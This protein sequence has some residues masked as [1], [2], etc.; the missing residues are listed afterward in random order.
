MESVD[1]NSCV[2]GGKSVEGIYKLF[3]FCLFELID[4]VPQVQGLKI[5]KAF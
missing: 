5:L 3:M 1:Q 4:I 2:V